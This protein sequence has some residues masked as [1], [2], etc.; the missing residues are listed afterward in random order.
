LEAAAARAFMGAMSGLSLE[1]ASALGAKLA[2]TI[3]PMSGAH[4]TILRNLEL[5]LPE[6]DATARHRIATHVWD[7]FG[8]TMT[9]YAALPRLAAREWRERITMSGHERLLGERKPAILFSGH[10]G[11]WETVPIAVGR[12]IRPMT[13]VYRP[14]NNPAV[15]AM[16][17][18]IRGRYTTALAPKGS[19]GARVIMKALEDG[20]LV[21]MIIDQKI[22][23]GL[24][25]PFFGRAA[26]TGTAVARFAMRFNCPLVPVRS[27][28]RDGGR[29]HVTV[30]E[31]WMIDG[32]GK[33]ED[34]AV[35]EALVRING[36]LESWIRE[37]PGQWLWMHK[38]WPKEA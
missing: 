30:E 5:S 38:R 12:M 14:P 19:G 8:R 24:P 25:I 4:R 34:E 20:E 22:N 35:R 7:N 16:I 1:R 3:G 17:T 27:E 2:R 6:L 29:F 26:M 21:A 11:N 10:I 36:K 32:T 28:R 15:D 13:V 23:E 18:G 37:D 9:E 31:P 33:S